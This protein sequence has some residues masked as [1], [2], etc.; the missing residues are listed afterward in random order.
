[1]YVKRIKRHI[2]SVYVKLSVDGG[3]MLLYTKV[4]YK[5]CK[6]C[7]AGALRTPWFESEKSGKQ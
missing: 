4:D 3:F 2:I 5:Y 1:M 6:Y 7:E